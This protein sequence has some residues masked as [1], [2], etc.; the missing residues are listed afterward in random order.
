[1]CLIAIIFATSCSVNST[2]GDF[3]EVDFLSEAKI[4]VEYKFE[5]FDSFIRYENGCLTFRY[6]DNCGAMSAT[7]V[8][9]NAEE[10]SFSNNELS[11][12]G[13]TDELNNNFL[14]FVIYE[15]LSANNGMIVAQMYDE[16]KECY[17]FEESVS[18]YF[19]RFEIY[20]HNQT[21]SYVIIIT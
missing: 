15:L 21:P 18:N 10:Y 17:Y 14:P 3:S 6:S 4:N 20:E 16:R 11:F 19:L 5:V 12:T 7:E 13:S 9:I 2:K 8:T 1:M